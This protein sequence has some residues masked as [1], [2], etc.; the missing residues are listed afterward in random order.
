MEMS[1]AA[2]EK[3]SLDEKLRTLEDLWESLSRDPKRYESPAWHAEELVET[4]RRH[5]L[6]LEAS[7]EWSAAKRELRK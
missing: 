6:G 3:M 2:I 4:Q 7:I 1:I 5:D